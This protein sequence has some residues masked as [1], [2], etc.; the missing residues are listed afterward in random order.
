MKSFSPAAR[1][2]AAV[3]LI[4]GLA[5]CGGYTAINLGGK[6][7]GLTDDGLVLANGSNTV[8]VPANAASYTFPQQIGNYASYAVTIQS[9][10]ARLT[11]VVNNPTGTASGIDITYVNV[12]CTP[13]TYNLGGLVSGLNGSVTLVN[14]SDNVTVTAAPGSTSTGF[15]FPNKVADGAVYSVAVLGLSTSGQTCTVLNNSTATNGTGT[16]GH[17][18]VKQDATGVQ[19]ICN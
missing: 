15:T 11:C 10:P 2:S 4:A 6:V 3:A 14:G 9:Q 1:L 19:V 16:M 13:N 8:A 7:V 5:A 12:T 17:S 18:D